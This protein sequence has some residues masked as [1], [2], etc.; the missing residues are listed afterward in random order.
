MV[1]GNLSPAA[2]FTTSYEAA[3]FI[4]AT[5]MSSPLPAT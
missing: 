1:S 3:R 5:Q 4:S 2:A